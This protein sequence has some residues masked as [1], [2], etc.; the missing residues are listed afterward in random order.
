MEPVA[1]PKNPTTPAKPFQRRLDKAFVCRVETRQAELDTSSLVLA[2]LG[3]VTILVALRSA[4]GQLNVRL[5]G[6]GY[7]GLLSDVIRTLDHITGGRYRMWLCSRAERVIW[8]GHRP[9]GLGRKGVEARMGGGIKRWGIPRVSFGLKVSRLF[10]I[11]QT[12]VY[13]S[14]SHLLFSKLP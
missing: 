13:Y 7:A 9:R 4:I 3:G 11:S 10:P 5:D 12:S 6:S 1:R 14:S 2:Q 8:K